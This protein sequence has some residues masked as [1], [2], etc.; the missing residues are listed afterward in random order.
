MRTTV[1]DFVI[2]FMFLKLITRLHLIGVLKGLNDKIRYFVPCGRDEV[3]PASA[4]AVGL[5]RFVVNIKLSFV[6]KKILF[7]KCNGKGLLI[8]LHCCFL[9]WLLFHS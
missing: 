2:L 1:F 4:V 5:C 8:F 9:E 6:D 3:T 7:D